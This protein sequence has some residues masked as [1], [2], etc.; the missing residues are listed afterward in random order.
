MKK[1]KHPFKPRTLEL[2]TET[3]KQLTHEQLDQVVGGNKTTV[4]SQCPTLCFE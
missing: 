1:H 3:L 2:K 4:K